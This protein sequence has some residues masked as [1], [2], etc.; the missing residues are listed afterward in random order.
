MGSG[1]L[2][3]G[4]FLFASVS[5]YERSRRY[6]RCSAQGYERLFEQS[7]FFFFLVLSY[8]KR[9]PAGDYGASAGGMTPPN[10]RDVRQEIV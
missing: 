2:V 7:F 3:F 5:A 1:F 4:D 9:A 10:T 8:L 6:R